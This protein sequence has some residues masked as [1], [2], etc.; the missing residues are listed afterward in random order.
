MLSLRQL[1]GRDHQF[2]ARVGIFRLIEVRSD[3]L[4]RGTIVCTVRRLIDHHVDRSRSRFLWPIDCPS[5]DA[6]S[7]VSRYL[8]RLLLG[9][10]SHRT[11]IV[12][13]AQWY[14]VAPV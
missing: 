5:R 10:I 4:S 1:S 12:D 2:K 11:D 7:R 8:Y 9:R 14:K 3:V 6:E 13:D